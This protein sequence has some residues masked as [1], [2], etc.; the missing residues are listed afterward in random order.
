[1]KLLWFISA[2]VTLSACAAVP[3]SGSSVKVFNLSQG[4]ARQEA[5]GKWEIYAP[6]N[7]FAYKTNGKCIAKG[8]SKPCM[9]HAVS[10]GY[11]AAEQITTLECTAV[12]SAPT[13]VVDPEALRA[14]NTKNHT[15]TSELHGRS[16]KVFW[17]GYIIRDE[18]PLPR[19]TTVACRSN[20]KTVLSY[21][22]SVTEQPNKPLEPTR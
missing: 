16:G 14:A 19:H 12:F 18:N 10:F 5:D 22:Y 15:F 7:N 13:D 8:E 9:W 3:D 11:S 1:M 2:A 4:L 6:G 21:S 20:G 17:Q